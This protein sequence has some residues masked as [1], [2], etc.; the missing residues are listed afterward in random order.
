M[1]LSKMRIFTLSIAVW[2]GRKKLKPEDIGIPAGATPPEVVSL[3]VKKTCPQERLTVFNTL[4]AKAERACQQHGLPF[5]GAY[6]V[7]VHKA[8]ALTEALEDLKRTFLDERAKFLADYDAI[9]EKWVRKHPAFEVALRKAITPASIVGTR[10]AFRYGSFEVQADSVGGDAQEMAD[11]LGDTLLDEVVRTANEMWATKI[12]GADEISQRGLSPI[13]KLR[14]KVDSLAFL[15]SRAAE[16]VNAI[17]HVLS[18]L[19]KTGPISN[20]DFML[21]SLLVS[22]MRTKANFNNLLALIKRLSA[23][24]VAPDA[25]QHDWGWAASSATEA[26]AASSAPRN[27]SFPVERKGDE[28]VPDERSAE[29]SLYW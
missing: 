18:A 13:R 4:R 15:D 25:F 9:V 14:D 27:D 17:D 20:R 12:D 19:P 26:D 24:V 7:P 28:G 23:S 16:V 2:T 8:E 10:L 11:E 6:A 3:G 29:S 5:L 1:N 22:Q 21:L